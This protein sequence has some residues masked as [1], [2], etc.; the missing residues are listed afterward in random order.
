MNITSY[1]F[2]KTSN[3]YYQY[4]F[5][6]TKDIISRVMTMPGGSLSLRV[7]RNESLMYYIY[8]SENPQVE[9]KFGLCVLVNGVMF[10]DIV[11]LCN[12]FED[13]VAYIVNN[14]D[15]LSFGIL[16]YLEC[17]SSLDAKKSEDILHRLSEKIEALEP[18][19]NK[20]PSQKYSIANDESKSFVYGKNDV[21]EMVDATADYPYTIIS[22]NGFSVTG[23]TK[24]ADECRR[25][26]NVIEQLN[27][28]LKA[29]TTKNRELQRTYDAYREWLTQK[30]D[31]RNKVAEAQ[32]KR[33]EQD[34]K[35]CGCSSGCS[36][37]GII[38]FIL[39]FII[40]CMTVFG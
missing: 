39:I 27:D 22:K 35:G 32:T 33:Y 3:S 18:Y 28:E 31:D 38:F 40:K 16:Q 11:K 15:V 10:T 36:W 4:P 2:Q 13:I 37:I 26:E 7:H 21:Q 12:A 30:L 1:I 24:I 6:Y 20:I 5:D 25:L 8:L 17:T 23:L 14:T 34:N 19:S 9:S 29:L